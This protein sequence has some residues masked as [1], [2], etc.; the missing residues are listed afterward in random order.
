MG[1]KKID[2]ALMLARRLSSFVVFA[3]IVPSS[4]AYYEAYADFSA[5]RSLPFFGVRSP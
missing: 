1:L 2:Q 4:D 3:P 5:V